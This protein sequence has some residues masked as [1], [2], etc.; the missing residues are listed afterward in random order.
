M[1]AKSI[2]ARL[3]GT[4]IDGVRNRHSVV[5]GMTRS[6]KTYFTGEVLKR[7][8]ED[9][10]HTIFVDPKHD[11]DYE[12]LGVVCYS[13]MEVYEKLLKKEPR[14]VFRTPATSPENVEALDRMVELVFNLQRTD[15]FRRIR[16]VIA[17][18]EL[19]LYTKK[20]SSKAIEMIWTVGAGLG[21]VGM[22]LTQRM[23]L[24]ND[25]VYTQS[26]NKF[27]FKI[28]DRPDYLRS[29]NLDHYPRD[30]FFQ[31][32]NRFWFYYTTGG[33]G[34]KKH[35]PVSADRPKRKGDLRLSRW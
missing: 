29:K 35:E 5:L 13:P 11:S 20:G 12:S 25:T 3:S 16:R 2:M 22:A 10:V 8:Q 18:D 7:L 1:K 24:L 33:G 31:D 6:G 28:D 15:G 4:M 17:I 27:I 23:Q 21:I 14:I 9:R 34:W 30:F 26:E 19:Q 32:M